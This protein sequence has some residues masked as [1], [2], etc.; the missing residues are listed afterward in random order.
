VL[1]LLLLLWASVAKLHYRCY[2]IARFVPPAALA[3]WGWSPPLPA[4]PLPA[5]SHRRAVKTCQ[6]ALAA[7]EDGEAL[8]AEG[9]SF[10]ARPSDLTALRGTASE[11]T[12][13]GAR[14]FDLLKV[15]GA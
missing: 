1:L 11:I 5:P 15:G 12:D 13:R 6:E 14:L 4:S 7:G 8:G 10:S 2:C 9:F 3:W